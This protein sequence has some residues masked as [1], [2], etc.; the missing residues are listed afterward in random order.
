MLGHFSK[1]SFTNGDMHFKEAHGKLDGLDSN[2]ALDYCPKDVEIW[3]PHSMSYADPQRPFA[4][5]VEAK[6]WNISILIIME[7]E[8][9]AKVV[10]QIFH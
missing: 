10:I 3:L 5:T 6:F 8:E 2:I 9:N 7:K 4:N 1:I